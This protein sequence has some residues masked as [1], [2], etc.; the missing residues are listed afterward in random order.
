MAI[1]KI[2]ISNLPTSAGLD[3]SECYMKRYKN[4]LDEVVKLAEQSYN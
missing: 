1:C 4:S 2:P 3:G